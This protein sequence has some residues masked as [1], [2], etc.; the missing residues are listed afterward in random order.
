MGVYQYTDQQAANSTFE[1]LI[2][3]NTQT[4]LT[5]MQTYVPPLKAE[6][7]FFV[8]DYKKAL[9][10][11]NISYVALRDFEQL[12]KF[13]KDPAFSLVFINTEVAVFKVNGNL[14]QD[15]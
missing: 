7:N 14:N 11:W 5:E 6:T 13:A 4:Y 2:E 1:E 9:A 15:G 8:F 10:D 12:P 3:Q